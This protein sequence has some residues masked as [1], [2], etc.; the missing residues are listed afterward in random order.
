MLNKKINAFTISELMVT[1]ALT[2][3]ITSF[4]Y[5]G[6]NYTQKLLH[7]FN[8]QNYFIVQ[9]TE[10][11]KRFDLLSAAVQEVTKEN[12]TRF[13]LKSDSLTYKIDFNS[14]Y[15]LLNKSGSVDTFHLKAVGLKS[16]FEV[17]NNPLWERKLINHF[18]FDIVYQK[19]RFHISFN[20]QY[21]AYSKLILETKN[22]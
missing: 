14:E 8:E 20:K 15:I 1:L 21:D 5:I 7:Q 3:I 13:I 19:E 16:D 17:M 12:E 4:A 2:G 22:N 10:L 6:F 9:L 18:A 11:N